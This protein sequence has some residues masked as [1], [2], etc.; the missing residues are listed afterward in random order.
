MLNFDQ[1]IQM[2]DRQQE[3]N[4]LI[5]ALELNIFTV[6]K[7]NGLTASQLAKNAKIKLDGTEPL[8]NALS[9]MGAIR[10][11]GELFFNTPESYKHFCAHSK[12]YKKGTIMLKLNNRR[13]WE[14]LI[15]TV[16]DGRNN[17]DYEGEDDPEFRRL[18]TYAM[19]ERSKPLTGSA[20]EFITRRP[21]GRLLDLGAGPGSYSFAIL[22]R[23]KKAVAYLLDR[24]AALKVAKKF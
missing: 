19:H 1:F 21:V 23:D 5:A 22:K 3:S 9:A 13:E 6:L 11:K 10:K 16:R 14:S 20:A 2:I 7:K 24:I 18:F 4:V 17:K 15:T 12:D 8:L